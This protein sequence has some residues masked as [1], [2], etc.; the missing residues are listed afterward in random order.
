M[1]SLIVVNFLKTSMLVNI[2]DG[3]FAKNGTIDCLCWIK[4][5]YFYSRIEIF[6]TANRKYYARE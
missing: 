3:S 2:M 6:L 4:K 5:K 1:T